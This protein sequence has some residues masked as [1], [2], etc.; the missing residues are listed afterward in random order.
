VNC[1]SPLTCQSGKC[2]SPFWAQDC[3]GIGCVGG[4]ANGGCCGAAPYC[5][6]TA[7]QTSQLVCVAVCRPY[8]FGCAAETDCCS[9]TCQSGVC[10]CVAQGGECGTGMCCDNAPYCVNRTGTPRCS[11]SCGSSGDGCGGDA[12]CC[13]GSQCLNGGSGGHCF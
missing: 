7:P 11:A 4:R 3:T 5:G 9:G 12:D 10:Q 8:G 6:S 2:L 1:C 13:P